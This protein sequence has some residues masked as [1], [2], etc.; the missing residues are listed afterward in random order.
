[1]IPNF[2][3]L[4]LQNQDI[5]TMSRSQEEECQGSQ[6]EIYSPIYFPRRPAPVDVAK[7]VS[8]LLS[9]DPESQM[10]SISYSH[11]VTPSH[12]VEEN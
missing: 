1:M 8:L 10:T 7:Y 11:L 3:S 6:R 4:V 5:P 12:S 2:H 9:V